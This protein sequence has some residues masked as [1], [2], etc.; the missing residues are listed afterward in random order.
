M[1][2]LVFA[3]KWRPQKFGEIVGQEHIVKTLKNAI[4]YDRIAH[5]YLLS[6]PRGIGK[7]STARIF[8]KVLNCTQ[9][10][11]AEPCG[12]CPSCLEIT[13]GSSMDVIEIDGASNNKVDDIR[14]IRETV[15]YMPARGKY[16]VYIIDEVHMVTKEGFNA[17]LKTLE[18][19]PPHVKFFFATTE[20]LKVPLTI[21]SRCQR[22]DF[23]KI[24][25]NII[26]DK[27]NQIAKNDKIKAEK[28][29]L[30]MIAR[31]AD[32][33][34]RD[35]ESI[36]DQIV[37]FTNSDIKE[38]DVVSMLGV[39]E[40]DLID[41]VAKAIVEGSSS[42][43]L[44]LVEKVFNEGKDPGTFLGG[45]IEYFRTILMIKVSALNTDELGL[46][47]EE[48]AGLRAVSEKMGMNTL[49]DIIVSLIDTEARISS[50]L[51]VKT[52]LE[53]RMLE[54][55]KTRQKIP[56]DEL[57]QK[58][59]DLKKKIDV[60]DAGSPGHSKKKQK[61]GE[62]PKT[63]KEPPAEYAAAD[64][65]GDDNLKQV[66]N[67]W[68]EAIAGISRMRPILKAYLV[69]GRPLRFDGENLVIGFDEDF[70]KVHLDAL[71]TPENIKI[72]ERQ[73]GMRLGAALSVAFDFNG[74]I[75]T[76]PA[77]KP[78]EPLNGTLQGIKKDPHVNRILDLFNAQIT[79]VKLGRDK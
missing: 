58:L 16:K 6:G 53:V 15:Q 36:L 68:H 54:L 79:D 8:A 11:D 43:I 57:V 3:R 13:S 48:A 47:E 65:S 72:I 60:S 35:A 37:S 76:A 71:K 44:K 9:P 22:L 27:L 21:R 70:Q 18:E 1:D 63:L 14:N 34:M 55:V 32:G 41:G 66:K 7:T 69:E 77:E 73:F 59:E 5:A 46:D 40:K 33:S 52:F 78:A 28:N 75:N 56:I 42:E 64:V 23:R 74:E 30:L 4:K 50:S 19:P 26:A 31:F 45:L 20:P 49:N 67:V 17:L 12:K 10:E 25:V 62:E 2:Y 38:Q 61:P 39:V 29:A 51:S 24:P